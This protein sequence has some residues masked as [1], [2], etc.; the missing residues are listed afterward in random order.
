MINLLDCTLRDGANIVGKGFSYEETVLILDGLVNSGIRAIEFGNCLG[1]GAYNADNAIAP[2]TDS[3]Y[4]RLARDYAGR[5][6]LGMFLMWK[7]G[8][9][10]VIQQAKNGGLSFLRVGANAGN[11][12]AACAAVRGVK[13]AGLYCRYALMKAYVLSPQELADEA[14]LLYNNGVDELIVMD[15]AGTMLPNEVYTYVSALCKRVPC[16]V[17]FHGHNNLGLSLGNAV[18]AYSAGATVIDTGLMGMARSAGNCATELVT[19][20]FKRMGLLPEINFYYLLDFIETKLMPAMTK[21][22]YYP[23]ILPKDIVLGYSGCHSSFEKLFWE[24]ANQYQVPLYPLIEEVS[25][26]DKLA[27]SRE[28]IEQTARSMT[29][30][31]KNS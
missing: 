5:A 16:P 3:E 6:E 18:A 22:N 26:K 4:L 31:V 9:K 12:N 13:D 10:D 30:S 25:K 8:T 19:A 17:G 7:N 2:L 11:G 14:L 23:P 28:F 29:G 27:P 20:V 15:S 24:V 1:I 21:Y